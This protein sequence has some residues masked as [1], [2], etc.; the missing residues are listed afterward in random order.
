[1]GDG[2]KSSKAKAVKQGTGSPQDVKAETKHTVTYKFKGDKSVRLPVAVAVDGKVIEKHA[3]RAKRYKM[4]GQKVSVS[5]KDKAKVSLY[6]NSDTH[7][8]YRESPVY[9]VTVDNCDILVTITRKSGKHNDDATPKRSNAADSKAQIHEYEAAL[10]GDIWMKVSHKYKASEVKA[11]LLPK[12]TSAEV[13]AAVKRIYGPLE[14]K[15]MT[16]RFPAPPSVPP[17]EDSLCGNPRITPTDGAAPPTESTEHPI[18]EQVGPKLEVTFQDANNPKDNINNFKLLEDGLTRVHPAAYAALFTAA[19]DAGASKLLV[20]SNWRP[21]LGSIVHRSGRG[22]DV[23][24]IDD[25]RMNRQELRG[26]GPD[27]TNVSAK[28]KGNFEALKDAEKKL[29]F[30][31]TAAE[32]IDKTLVAAEEA[33]AKQQESYD[34]VKSDAAKEPTAKVDLEAAKK[35]RADAK[36]AADEAS[37][38]IAKAEKKVAE[39]KKAW[40]KERDAN[41][42]AVVKKFRESLL[43]S[44]RVSQV[45]GP[46]VME[47]STSDE[48]APKPNIQSTANEKIHSHHLHITIHDR[49]LG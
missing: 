35:A 1:M 5:V 9:E 32:D 24:K 46:W 39:A 36:S 43:S 2:N 20:S 15:V 34:A 30:E 38:A 14:S 21:L 28:E 42:P 8:D 26:I 49:K 23:A 7:P 45:M 10:T 13:I 16:I 12:D 41:Q 29:N 31:T 17:V 47:N 6:L 4:N 22:I 33:L 3:E 25:I 27:T 44:S 11:A 37:E 18:N 48:I 40:E 19:R